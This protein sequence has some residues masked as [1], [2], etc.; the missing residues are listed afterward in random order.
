LMLILG[1]KHPPVLYWE[2]PLDRQRSIIGLICFII[3]IITFVPSPF[4]VNF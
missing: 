2:Q 4:N 1:I 3:F